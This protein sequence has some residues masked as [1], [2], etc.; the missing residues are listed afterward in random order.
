[1]IMKS[2]YTYNCE[3]NLISNILF[4]CL[5]QFVIGNVFNAYKSVNYVHHMVFC[6]SY[7][8]ETANIVAQHVW[9]TGVSLL[10]NQ[11]MCAYKTV[12]K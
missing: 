6:S 1:M 7:A 8:M 5:V 10:S 12:E 9:I 4:S 3:M 11:K 2:G